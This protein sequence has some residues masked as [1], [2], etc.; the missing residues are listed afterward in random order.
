MGRV[1]SFSSSFSYFFFITLTSR[2]T[3]PEVIHP[4][5]N[6]ATICPQRQSACV[7]VESQSPEPE[8]SGKKMGREDTYPLVEDLPHA[9]VAH[10][11]VVI[12]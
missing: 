4:S 6:A 2:E 7:Y 9:L 5:G 1:H 11:L 3:C 8:I 12:L 10:D